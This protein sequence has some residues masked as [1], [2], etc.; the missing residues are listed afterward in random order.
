MLSYQMGLEG[1]SAGLLELGWAI[2]AAPICPLMLSYQMGLEDWNV[3]SQGVVSLV[4]EDR[5]LSFLF[6]CFLIIIIF[7]SLERSLIKK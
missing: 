6:S 5:L 1:L 2:Y 7:S 3:D 4:F